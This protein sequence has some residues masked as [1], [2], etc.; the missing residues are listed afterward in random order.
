MIVQDETE[1]LC[2]D[3]PPRPRIVA[4]DEDAALG[5]PIEA[6]VPD[7]VQDMILAAAE[8]SLQRREPRLRQAMQPHLAAVDGP[9]QGLVQP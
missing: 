1:V 5:F 8:F 2:C 6:G 9:G 4:Q 3:A 7:K